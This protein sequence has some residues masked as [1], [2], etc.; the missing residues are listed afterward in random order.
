MI[1]GK[2]QIPGYQ[3]DGSYTPNPYYMG[4]AIAQAKECLTRGQHPVGAVITQIMTLPDVSNANNR[5][6]VTRELIAGL[7][8][9]SVENDSTGHAEI[10][11]LRFAELHFGRRQLGERRSVLYATHAPCP[12]CAGTITNSKLSCIVYGTDLE[13]A[14]AVVDEL[15]IKWRSN[16]VS[17]LDVIRGR[18]E[19][20]A[21]E[22]FIIG[23]FMRAECLELLRS[24]GELSVSEPTLPS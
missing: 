17:G 21:P 19:N 11:A 10:R 5:H 4:E 2:P 23:G 1:F 22:Q 13:D 15:G 3:K 14:A 9:N 6:F 24:V 8:A 16:R 7:G 20:G 12:M 18:A